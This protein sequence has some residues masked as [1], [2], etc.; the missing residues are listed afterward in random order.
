VHERKIC[1]KV[2]TTKERMLEDFWFKP[3][4]RKFSGEEFVEKFGKKQHV[5]WSTTLDK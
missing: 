4:I 2:I 5:S 3:Y 1:N